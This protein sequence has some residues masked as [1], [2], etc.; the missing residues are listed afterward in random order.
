MVV[1]LTGMTVTVAVAESL[2]GTGLTADLLATG[3]VLLMMAPGASEGSLVT[4]RINVSVAAARLEKLAVT[5]VPVPPL[6]KPVVAPGNQ[7]DGVLAVPPPSV[8]SG[9]ACAY[10]N[11]VG[12]GTAVTVNVPLKGEAGVS[13]ETVTGSPATI[14]CGRAVVTGTSP[15]LRTAPAGAGMMPTFPPTDRD[16]GR[17]VATTTEDAP[18]PRLVRLPV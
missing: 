5:G 9:R 18:G 4:L 15:P 6:Q 14:A 1:V 17:L 10:W 11:D 16:A 12:V 3:M 8:A 2:A 13:S 7:H